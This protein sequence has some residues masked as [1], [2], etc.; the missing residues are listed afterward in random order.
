MTIHHLHRMIINVGHKKIN[1][2]ILQGNLK[3]YPGNE[4]FIVWNDFIFFSFSFSF[5]LL[6]SSPFFL[7]KKNLL[8]NFLFKKK[9][10]WWNIIQ[11]QIDVKQFECL[12]H[13]FLLRDMG[14]FAAQHNKHQ[15][16]LYIIW[17]KKCHKLSY[18]R[19]RNP[20]VNIQIF[21]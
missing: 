10:L 8:K 7:I 15:I 12:R 16:I 19:I 4:L 11:L 17:V 14:I 2:T 9:F 6:I 21:M 3:F 18:L 13:F 20:E 5:F 1:Y